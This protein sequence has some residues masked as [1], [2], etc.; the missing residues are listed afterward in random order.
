VSAPTAAAGT[1]GAARTSTRVLAQARFEL[2][3]VLRNGEQLMVTLVLPLLALLTLT[4]IAVPGGGRHARVEQVA[5]SVLAFA[6]LATSFT[7]QAISTAFDR[8]NGVLRLLATTP[9]GR[10]GLLAGKVLAVLAVQ[11]LGGALL[12]AVGL[13]LGWR[14]GA[15]ALAAA[16]AIGVLGTAAFVALALLVAGT[17]RAEAVLAV[18]NLALIALALGGGVLI[19]SHDLPGPLA[20]LAPLLPS[21]ALADAIRA[22]TTGAGAP[23]AALAVLTGWTALL[24]AAAARFFRWD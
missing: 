8:R 9:L 2:R 14:P 23:V 16:A 3:A 22:V 13:G 10:S 5:P 11:V 17:L 6:V 12:V 4:L 1:A 20:A 15:G 21:G 18:A 19:P 24:A 7:S